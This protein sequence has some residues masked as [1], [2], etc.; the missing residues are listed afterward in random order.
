M[1]G[2]ARLP[3]ASDFRFGLV[4][5]QD[6]PM[7]QGWLLRPHVAQW[8]GPAE[9]IEQLHADHVAGQGAPGATLAYIASLNGEPVGFIQS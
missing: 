6:L 4:C 1:D 2:A 3:G 5:A 7:L 9:S 8:R